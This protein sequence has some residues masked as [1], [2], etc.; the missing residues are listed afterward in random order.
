MTAS[1]KDSRFLQEILTVFAHH[2]GFHVICIYHSAFQIPRSGRLSTTHWILMRTNGDKSMSKNLFSQMF[3]DYR[4][5]MEVYEKC[6]SKPYSHLLINN[7]PRWD[8]KFSL[9][10]SILDDPV[11]VYC[12]R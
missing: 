11:T 4:G 5:A 12:S 7:S 1:S 6:M 10:S 2:M 9:I 8:R 3:G